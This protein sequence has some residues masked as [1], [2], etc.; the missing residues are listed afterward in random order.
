MVLNRNKVE[1]REHAA[2]GT[3]LYKSFQPSVLTAKSR[4]VAQML[5]ILQEPPLVHSQHVIR[6]Q[7]HRGEKRREGEIPWALDQVETEFM[8]Y[9][10]YF[11]CIR[12]LR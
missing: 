8:M 2:N 11:D 3:C 7:L 10:G 4:G 6:H 5:K 1:Y 9:V 12:V